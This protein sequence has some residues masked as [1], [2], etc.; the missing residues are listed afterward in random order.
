MPSDRTIRVMAD[1]NPHGFGIAYNENYKLI[2]KKTMDLEEYIAWC[3]EV[4]QDSGA[5][6]H[7]RIATHGSV[8]E[9]NCHPFLSEDGNLAFAHNGVLSIHNRGDM[10]DSETF[11]RDCL[12][13][14]WNLGIT[15]NDYRFKNACDM[16][17][18]SSKFS[19]IDNEGNINYM[20]NWIEDEELL[21][22]NTSYIDYD[23]F[24]GNL[25]DGCSDDVL[26]NEI[27]EEIIYDPYVSCDSL[28]RWMG[29]GVY[30]KKVFKKA[31]DSAKKMY[32]DY[33]NDAW[34]EYSDMDFEE[35]KQE[36][37]F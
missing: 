19:F 4:P 29:K 24:Y 37:V 3:H 11:F 10:T 13:H 7:L 17:I 16:V 22:S 28:Y 33:I 23:S 26:T 15:P 20:G 2:V 18:G 25:N 6:L 1:A 36:G 12:E 5:I 35:F 34:K 21:F 9:K 8:Q 14:L 32:K 27:F 31:F 30:K